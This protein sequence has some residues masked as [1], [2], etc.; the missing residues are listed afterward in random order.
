MARIYRCSVVH[1]THRTSDR[2]EHMVSLQRACQCRHVAIE[3]S[4]RKLRQC[5]FVGWKM[6]RDRL[7]VRKKFRIHSNME[8]RN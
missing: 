6:L 7:P 2:Q 4:E 3:Q 1:R 5:S 8:H